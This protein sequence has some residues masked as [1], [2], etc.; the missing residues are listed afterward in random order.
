MKRT[1]LPLQ[2]REF[3]ALL[4][5]AAAAWPLAARAQ[6]QHLAKVWQIG[7]LETTSEQLNARNLLALRQGLLDLGYAEGRNL[8]IEYRSAEG[9]PERFEELAAELVR[10]KI[11]VIVA[12]GTPAIM[13]AKNASETVPIV[14]TASAQ[15]FTFVTSLA[16]PGGNVTGLSSLASDLYGK[17]IELIKEAVSAI[18]RVGVMFNSTNPNYGKNSSEVDKAALSLGIE[19]HKFDLR[20]PDDIALAFEKATEQRVDALVVGIDTVTQANSHFIAE[21]AAKHRLPAIYAGREFVETGGLMAYGVNYPDLYRRAAAFVDKI[22][23][24]SNPANLPIEQPTRFEL[25][26]NLKTS[27]TLGIE[28]PRVPARPRRR[29]D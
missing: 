22:I 6:Q 14:M 17:R 19:L 20:Q 28:I 24:G 8:V 9:H 15:P 18:T 16:R 11:D 25:L 2:R 12:R 7:L 29:G 4:G 27:K 1:S 21:L 10:V 3:I 26:I 5:G 13:A 23:K